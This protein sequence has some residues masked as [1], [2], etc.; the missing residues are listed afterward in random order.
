MPNERADCTRNVWM[1]NVK[2][3]RPP[4]VAEPRRLLLLLLLYITPSMLLTCHADH[5]PAPE[6]KNAE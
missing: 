1:L 5:M 2:I 6:M 4:A 3:C